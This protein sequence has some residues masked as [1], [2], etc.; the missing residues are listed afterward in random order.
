MLNE[1]LD[2]SITAQYVAKA[3]SRA[4]GLLI[5]KSKLMGGMPLKTFEKLFESTVI[6]V[7]SYGSGIWGQ[8]RYKCIDMVQNRAG[9]FYL[10]VGKSAPNAAVFGDLGWTPIHISQWDSVIRQYRRFCKMDNDRL[11]KRIFRWADIQT[12]LNWNATVHRKLSSLNLA[13]LANH[14]FIIGTKKCVKLVREAQMNIYL[15]EWTTEIMRQ[16]SKSGNGLNK[17]RTYRTFKSTYDVEHYNTII[18]PR[19]HRSALAK[20]RMGTAPIRIETGRY[21]RI[22]ADR[23]FCFHCESCIE[24]EIHVLVEC[25]LYEDLRRELYDYCTTRTSDNLNNLNDCDKLSA[26]LSNRNIIRHS[27]KFCSKVLTRRYMFLNS[28]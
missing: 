2:Y 18:L 14:N 27:A 17:L 1:N 7:I 5:S 23:R 20:F 4:L 12:N 22:P 13:Q 21:E 10:G 26:I 19:L 3:A 8:K 24:D 6:S 28:R 9:R 11:N 25:P 15:T 16:N